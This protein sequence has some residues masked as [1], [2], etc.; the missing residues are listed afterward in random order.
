M[1]N[2]D[3]SQF[4]KTKAQ[5]NDFST[6]LSSILEKMFQSDFNLEKALSEEFG[7]IKK[8]LFMTFLRESNINGESIADVKTFLTKVQEKIATLPV[9]NLAIAFEPKEQTLQ[10]LS[11]WFTV[12]LHKQVLFEITIDPSLIAGA[13]LSFQGT[14]LDLSIKETFEKYLNEI[15]DNASNPTDKKRPVLLGGHQSLEHITIGR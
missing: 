9:L 3:V 15:V 11:N 5:A 2:I 14:Y 8:D 10:V 7:L 12:N 6:H 4:V 13:T 1:D